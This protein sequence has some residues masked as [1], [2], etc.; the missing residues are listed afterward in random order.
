MSILIAFTFNQEATKKKGRCPDDHGE[1]WHSSQDTQTESWVWRYS[2][3][4]K[5]ISE[6]RF[7]QWFVITYFVLLLTR[8]IVY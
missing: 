4:D 7:P 1:S 6:Q 5:P 8:N 3:I 2:F